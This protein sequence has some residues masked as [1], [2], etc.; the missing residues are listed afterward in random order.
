[1]KPEIF[2]LGSQGAKQRAIK[3]INDLEING[4]VSVK[5]ADTG[6]RSARQNALYWQW[7][8]EIAEAGIGGKH[9][10]TKAGAHIVCKYRFARPII[11]RDMPEQW[12]FLAT[13]EREYTDKPEALFYIADNFIS[14]TKFSTAQMAEY[15][16]D[17][18]RHYQRKG[19]TF[20][21]PDRGLLEYA[22]E[23]GAA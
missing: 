9:E 7:V 6:S 17:I 23:R 21:I 2:W 15:M 16:T 5:I 22:E 4:S 14:T 18:E 20:T 12:E 11:N 3:R 13:L 10:E 1:M 8:T 19:V